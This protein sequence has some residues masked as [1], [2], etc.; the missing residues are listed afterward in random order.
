LATT[1]R[2]RLLVS[3]PWTLAK[4]QASVLGLLPKP[5]LTLDQVELLKHDNVVS[6]DAKREGRTLEGLGITPRSIESIVP[7]YLF[8]YRKAGQFTSPGKLV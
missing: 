2:K 7:S 3:L 8:R 5:L 6:A 4:A 1:D